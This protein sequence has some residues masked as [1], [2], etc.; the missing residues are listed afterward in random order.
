MYDVLA[1]CRHVINYSNKHNYGISNL[2]LQKLL[3][4]I[5]A[6]FLIA[7]PNNKACFRQSIEAWDFGPVVPEAYSAYKQYGSVSIP[8][9]R[10]YYPDLLRNKN[11]SMPVEYKDNEI[12]DNDKKLIDA[13]IERLSVYTATDLVKIT[14]NQQTWQNAYNRGYN[15]EITLEEMRKYFS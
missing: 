11:I 4:F 12:L 14:H 2:K 10:Y 7:S 9:V 1:V 6:Y 8:P 5:Q 15:R 13:V 3:Y